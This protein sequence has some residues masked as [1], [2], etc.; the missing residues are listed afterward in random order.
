MVVVYGT[1]VWYCSVVAAVVL[2]IAV[3]VDFMQGEVI[4]NLESFS[5]HI[6]S[7]DY[8]IS[9]GMQQSFEDLLYKYKVD[10]A[11]WAHYHS[12]ERTCPVYKNSCSPGAPIHIVVGTAGKEVDTADYFNMNWSLYHENN[13]GYGRLT[14]ANRSALLWQWVENTSG[15]VKDSVW[16]TK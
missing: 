11:F 7:E 8:V 1:S 13:Y 12:Y 15:Q 3:A 4:G 16:L 5:F 14:Q 9:L 10:I 2:C 6:H